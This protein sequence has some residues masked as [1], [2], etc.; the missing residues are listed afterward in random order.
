MEDR[1]FKDFGNGPALKGG[2]CRGCGKISFPMKPVCPACFGSEQQE[3]PLSNKG[4]LH[5]FALS[6]MGPPGMEVPYLIGFVDLPEGIKLFSLLTE[7]E[8]WE[9]ALKVDMEMEMVVETIRR[10]EEGTEIVGYKFRP[11]PERCS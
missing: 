6:H 2:R 9:E 1:W 3:I 8:P 11:V 10:D 5:T 4:K 7:C